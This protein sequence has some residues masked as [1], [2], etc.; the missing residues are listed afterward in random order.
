MSGRNL[1][2][3]CCCG[4]CS[5]LVWQEL[6]DQFDAVSAFF[7]NPNIQP[8]TE[9]QLR[10]QAMNT[11]GDRLGAPLIVDCTGDL[12]WQALTAPFQTEPEGGKRCQECF[13]YRLKKTFD[14]A[15]DLGFQTVATTLTVSRFKNSKT[16]LAIGQDLSRQYGI[17]FLARDFKKANGSLMADQKAREWH[18]YRQNYCGCLYSKLA[19]EQ[20]LIR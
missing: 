5:A 13:R 19:R 7:F 2:L 11:V 16:I 10:L 8:E 4:P 15:L 14:N 18:L 17:T 9:Y 6:L 1:L 12:E 3:H 20:K